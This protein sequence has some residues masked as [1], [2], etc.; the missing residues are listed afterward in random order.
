M[1]LVFEIPCFFMG[2]GWV[3]RLLSNPQK[4]GANSVAHL[5]IGVG[6]I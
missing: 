5:V 4:A 1:T 3:T 2:E 6:P